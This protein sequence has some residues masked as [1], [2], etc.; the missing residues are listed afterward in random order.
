MKLQWNADEEN[1][2]FHVYV[3]QLNPSEWGWR[4]GKPAI[5]FTHLPSHTGNNKLFAPA[6]KVCIVPI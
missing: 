3:L 1:F 4:F 6:G 5:M 2:F